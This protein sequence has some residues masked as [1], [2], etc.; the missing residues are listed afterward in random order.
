MKFFR[1]MRGE[2][3]KAACPDIQLVQ[4]PV[5]RGKADLNTYRTAGSEV[6]RTETM[7]QIFTSIF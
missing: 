6:V 7:L 5:A 2:E 1:S 3:A 4:V